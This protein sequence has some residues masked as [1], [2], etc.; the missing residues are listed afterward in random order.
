MVE[1]IK[2]IRLL[3]KEIWFLVA[4]QFFPYRFQEPATPVMEGIVDLYN[5]ICFYLV[6]ILFVLTMFARILAHFYIK[7]C[8]KKPKG[9]VQGW[10]KGLLRT[11]IMKAASVSHSTELEVLWTIVPSV[12]LALI[13]APSFVLLYAMDEVI[14]PTMT[15]KVIGHQWY[16]VYDYTDL[17]NSLDLDKSKLVYSSYMLPTEVLQNGEFRLLEVDGPLYLP[18]QTQIRMII[19]ASD[20]LHSWAVPQFGIKMDAVPGRLNAVSLFVKREG[21]YYGQCSEICGVYHGFMPIKVEV[22]SFD[23]YV[24]SLDQISNR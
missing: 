21:V 12:I 16:W 5:Y 18:A 19:T 14:D 1:F 8:A 4:G 13:A 11:T 10:R 2:L 7:R 23:E 3:F 6:I 17:S 20:V 24:R 22:V 9:L 15:I